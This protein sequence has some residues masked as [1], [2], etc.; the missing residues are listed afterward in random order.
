MPRADSASGLPH[1]ITS[2]Q[3]FAGG[4]GAFCRGV[5]LRGTVNSSSSCGRSR[6]VFL[7]H[8]LHMKGGVHPHSIHRAGCQPHSPGTQERTKGQRG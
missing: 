8:S 1:L 5:V 4:E 6:L 3:E 7:E 2:A